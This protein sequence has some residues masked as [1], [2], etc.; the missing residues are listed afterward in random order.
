MLGNYSLG[1]TPL[2]SSGGPSSSAF[3]TGRITISSLSPSVNTQIFLPTISTEA[4]SFEI[5]SNLSVTSVRINVEIKTPL[6]DVYKGKGEAMYPSR[7]NM[8]SFPVEIVKNRLE[9]ISPAV[10]ESSVGAGA[11]IRTATVVDSSNT[12]I[13]SFLLNAHRKKIISVPPVSIDVVSPDPEIRK[14]RIQYIYPSIMYF[15]TYTP[16]T[17]ST[18]MSPTV[19]EYIENLQ[20]ISRYPLYKIDLLRY[21]ESVLLTIS[22]DVISDS[23][24]V[25][26]Q[27]SVGVRRT[28]DFAIQNVTHNYRAFVE[29]IT[30]GSKFRVWLGENIGGQP[31]Y[32]SQGVYMFDNP[33]LIHASSDRR[34]SVSGTD[35]W[36]ILN[37]QNGGILEGTYTVS[38]GSNVGD[39]V[40]R[41]LNLDIVNDP[42]EPYI[43]PEL[44][45]VIITYDITKTDGSTIADVFLDV[46]LNIN[47]S[48]YYDAWGRF[49]IVPIVED[50]FKGT[51][52]AF[53]GADYNYLDGQ[54]TYNY[55]EIYNS[56][57]IVSNNA[58]PGASTQIRYEELNMDA[59]DPNSIVNAGIKKVYK[60]KDYLSGI[61]TKEK[62]MARAGY[63]SRNIRRRYSSASVNS[64]SILHLGEGDVISLSDEVLADSGERFVV[65]S[66]N[67]PIGTDMRNTITVS[68]IFD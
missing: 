27:D 40:R 35:K 66:I 20:S 65:N 61:D 4:S 60:V 36:S 58:Q 48:V 19:L 59:S 55:T 32:F 31:I 57:L 37:G 33:S 17:F 5:T 50:R 67:R 30:I 54:K 13:E 8:R 34:L 28:C 23:G 22:E 43:A 53:G 38:A 51:A 44:E 9:S 11:Y 15:K 39:F 25:N 10:I 45:N 47:A 12:T 52:F 3:D 18:R 62:A 1:L 26:I 6:P 63:E 24:S 16:K 7:L 29:N 64:V 49:C 56:V 41:T 46:A 14:A 2:G 68:K 42:I 21:D